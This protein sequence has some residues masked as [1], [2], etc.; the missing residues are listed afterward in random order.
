MKLYLARDKDG[1]LCLYTTKPEKFEGDNGTGRIIGC[2]EIV[3]DY[4]NIICLEGVPIE[5]EFIPKIFPEV[6]WEDNEPTEVE[7]VIKR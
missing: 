4:G 6:K 7:L 5:G 2:W 1:C 3:D